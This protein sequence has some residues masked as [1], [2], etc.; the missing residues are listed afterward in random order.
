MMCNFGTGMFVNRLYADSGKL[1]VYT[2]DNNCF[3]IVYSSY[4]L[5]QAVTS[6]SCTIYQCKLSY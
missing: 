6:V 1:A 5:L 3:K 4:M 2:E